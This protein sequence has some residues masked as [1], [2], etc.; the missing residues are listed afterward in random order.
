MHELSI[1]LSLIEVIRDQAATWTHAR[2]ERIHVQVGELS[3]IVPEALQSAFE[4]A[5]EGT[6]LSAAELQL[7]EVPVTIACPRCLSS[8]PA[9]APGDLRC[10]ACGT[11]ATKVTGGRE[12]ELVAVEVDDEPR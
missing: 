1:A 11:V 12:M 9:V 6:E 4:I 5:R 8:Q 3:G 2:V 7:E 10:A